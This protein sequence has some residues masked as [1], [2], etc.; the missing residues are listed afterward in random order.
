[1]PTSSSLRPHNNALRLLDSSVRL[2]RI[3][4]LGERRA[5]CIR[6]TGNWLAAAGFRPGDNIEVCV[7]SG[8]LSITPIPKKECV[9][10]APKRKRAR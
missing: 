2:M 8:R 5:A 7:S 3:S 1:M 6:L 4:A 10:Q 9:Y